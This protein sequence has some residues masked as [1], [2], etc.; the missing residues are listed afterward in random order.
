MAIKR[1][2]WRC[3]NRRC[4]AERLSDH[5][6]PRCMVCGHEMRPWK[7]RRGV[8]PIQ[9]PE[10]EWGFAFHPVRPGVWDVIPVAIRPGVA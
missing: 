2:R 7:V 4:K 10:P 6:D 1:K 5:S 8:T 9:P 3:V